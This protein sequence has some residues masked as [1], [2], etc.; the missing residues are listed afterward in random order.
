MIA[1][2]RNLRVHPLVWAL[3]ALQVLDLAT[4]ALVLNRGGQE[5]N[6]LI[7]A[8][9]W[10]W[11][12]VVKFGLMLGLGWLVALAPTPLV[13]RFVSYVVAIYTLVVAWNLLVAVVLG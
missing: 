5:T 1:T 9:G 2:L 3:L 7:N 13:L 11:S 4:T 10:Q 6:H 12:I 8:I